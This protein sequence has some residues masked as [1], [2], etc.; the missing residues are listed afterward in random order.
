[1]AQIERQ[2]FDGRYGQTIA[3]ALVQYITVEERR[4]A[5]HISY[6][7]LGNMMKKN[8]APSAHGQTTTTG[9]V[10]GSGR[11]VEVTINDLHTC[12]ELTWNKAAKLVHEYIKEKNTGN[13]EEQ[14]DEINAL[15]SSS[16][17]EDPDDDYNADYNDDEGEDDEVTDIAPRVAEALRCHSEILAGAE[18]AQQGLYRMA[19]AFRQMRDE[20]LY[21]A[22]GYSSFESYCEK[23]TGLK[24]VQVYSYI[25]IV[26]RLPAEFVQSTER[27]GVQKLALLSTLSEEQ[28][29]DVA[30]S[31]DLESTTVR[32][33]RERIDELTGAVEREKQLKEDYREQGSREISQLKSELQDVRRVKGE[34]AA[35][36][37]RMKGIVSDETQKRKA[38][39]KELEALHNGDVR[40][41]DEQIEDIAEESVI[42]QDLRDKIEQLGIEKES[43]ERLTEEL[44]KRINELEHD[45]RELET[46]PVDVIVED[47]D[48]REQR[49]REAEFTVKYKAAF[50]YVKM[51]CIFTHAKGNEEM[52][53]RTLSLC[54]LIKTTV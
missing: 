29:A 40:L 1:M 53:R 39:E 32:E 50:E 17:D 28:R 31:V 44:Q 30:Q 13:I 23:E 9:F 12:F 3:D 16:P 38:L 34:I 11:G 27:I 2:K 51:L 33:L 18:L 14:I 8:H 43:G 4:Q 7:D 5:G 52:K 21:K 36:V 42:V 54:E 46:R 48:A 35:E 10:A 26:E 6:G 37:G 15:V 47:K 45:I 20:K 24:K 25:K 22:L 19:T 41:T 49:L